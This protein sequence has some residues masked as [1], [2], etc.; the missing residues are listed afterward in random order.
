MITNRL[1][2]KC[3][4]F[5]L[6][7][8]LSYLFWFSWVIYRFRRA[9]TFLKTKIDLNDTFIEFEKEKET[10]YY[11]CYLGIT[12]ATVYVQFRRDTGANVNNNSCKSDWSRW[13]EAGID[14]TRMCSGFRTVARARLY[15]IIEYTTTDYV[16]FDEWGLFSRIWLL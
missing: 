9:Y 11:Y 16:I 2:E 15:Q 6:I 10:I 1:N 7:L 3:W 14:F 13:R 5:Y 8:Y 12:N 4:I